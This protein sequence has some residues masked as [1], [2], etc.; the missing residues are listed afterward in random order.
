MGD[1]GSAGLGLASLKS[2][3]RLRGVGAAPYSSVSGPGYWGQV[4]SGPGCESLIEKEVG[5]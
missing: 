2:I 1:S 3:S 5:A 4:D